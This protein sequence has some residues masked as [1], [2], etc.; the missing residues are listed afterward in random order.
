VNTID[1]LNRRPL[2]NGS[3]KTSTEH[4]TSLVPFFKRQSG[5]IHPF[6]T[7][8][9][10]HVHFAPRLARIGQQPIQTLHQRNSEPTEAVT[11]LKSPSD[12]SE[13]VF[14]FFGAGV[15]TSEPPR[16]QTGVGGWA[17]IRQTNETIR[18]ELRSPAP[19]SPTRWLDLLSGE[20]VTLPARLAHRGRFKNPGSRITTPCK[21]KI[22]RSN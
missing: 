12:L 15:G 20:L 13:T 8:Q 14:Y 10:S 21:S 18:A 7:L 2:K 17:R 22:S 1:V 5:M 6:H 11:R 9:D 3:R 4:W 19:S 16:S